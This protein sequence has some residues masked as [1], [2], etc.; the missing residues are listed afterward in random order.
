M[1]KIHPTAIIGENVK[2]GNNNI[3]SPFAVLEGNVRIGDNNFI[4][5]GVNITNNVNIGND[6]KIY[7][8]V[9][10]GN[11]GE[12]GSKGDIFNEQSKVQIGN[13]NTIREFS[14]INFPVRKSETTINNNCYLMSRTHVPH[15]A[16]LM[17]NVVLA[18]N[19]LIGGGCI[20]YDYAYIGLGAIVHQ[21]INI[22]ESAMIGLQAGIT[23]NVPPFCVTV[24]V[25]GR[26]V[27]LNKVG[28]ERRGFSNDEIIEASSKL[29]EILNNNY[30]SDNPIIKT[31][32]NFI[33]NQT[34]K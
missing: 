16:T 11:L 24:G 10:I 23:K 27:N 22:G 29:K 28:A 15:D 17:N 31:I 21:W 4:G 19:S 30:E 14:T 3:I 1:N 9:S 8:Y 33:K 6:N 18:T 26:I 12:M 13:N 7:N 34:V 2:L 32:N 20:I 25:P 5:I